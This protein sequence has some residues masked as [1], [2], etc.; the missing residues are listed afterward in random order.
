MSSPYGR[1]ISNANIAD[2]TEFGGV[3]NVI[4][5]PPHDVKDKPAE[6]LML[7]YQTNPTAGAIVYQDGSVAIEDQP[8]PESKK[9]R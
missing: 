6:G 4:Q 3:D 5:P 8:I 7:M 9:I 1:L 2:G